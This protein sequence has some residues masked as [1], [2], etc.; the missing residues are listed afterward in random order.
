MTPQQRLRLYQPMARLILGAMAVRN[1]NYTDMAARM[2]CCRQTAAQKLRSPE[3]MTLGELR[4]V[5]HVLGIQ[6]ELRTALPM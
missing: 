5:G 6:E 3:L 4:T 2:G 1:L